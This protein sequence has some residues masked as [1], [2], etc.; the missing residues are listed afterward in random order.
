MWGVIERVVLFVVS[1]LV[2][3]S[4]VWLL[5]TTASTISKQS[6]PQPVHSQRVDN[7]HVV[8]QQKRSV[9]LSG[10]AYSDNAAPATYNTASSY[11]SDLR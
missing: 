11:Y 1:V 9:A 8:Q 5:L 3:V 4:I 10:V 2:L 7:Y 6:Q